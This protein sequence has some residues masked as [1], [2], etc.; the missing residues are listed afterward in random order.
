M[1]HDL[2][3]FVSDDLAVETLPEGQA[4]NSFATATSAGSFSCPFTSA[5]SASSASSYSG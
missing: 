4:L 3:L 5:S 1:D 2:D